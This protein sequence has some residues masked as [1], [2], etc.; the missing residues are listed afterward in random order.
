MY[1]QSSRGAQDLQR[2]F[3]LLMHS[4][5]LDTAGTGWYKCARCLPHLIHQLSHHT[6]LLITPN[7]RISFDS[8]PSPVTH[9]LP[10]CTQSCYH[11]HHNVKAVPVRRAGASIHPRRPGPHV[12]RRAVPDGASG[13]GCTFAFDIP[14]MARALSPPPAEARRSLA[15]AF[16]CIVARFSLN[17][18]RVPAAPG[19]P[20]VCMVCKRRALARRRRRQL[21]ALGCAAS[22]LNP[23][24]ASSCKLPPHPLISANLPPCPCR[25]YFKAEMVPFGE[26]APDSPDASALLEFYTHSGMIHWTLNVTD[27][28]GFS[29]AKLVYGSPD[30]TAVDGEWGW[31]GAPAVAACT[32]SACLAPPG[33]ATVALECTTHA[34]MPA[35]APAAAA[36]GACSGDLRCPGC[37]VQR[38][39]Q[40]GG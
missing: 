28:A 6:R 39:R 14:C 37:P 27:V 22:K 32:S 9:P 8:F 24:P 35:G 25:R 26:Q 7:S 20:L 21:A 33:A 40:L 17:C 10:P 31:L 18:R 38:H 30:I 5:H 23:L 11:T 19:T 3:V 4:H 1:S 2:E 16:V 13:K 15:V 34:D 29:K 12:S 36:S